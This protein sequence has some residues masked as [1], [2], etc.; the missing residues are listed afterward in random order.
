MLIANYKYKQIDGKDQIIFQN[1]RQNSFCLTKK[2]FNLN[3]LTQ[4]LMI[5]LSIKSSFA[6][7]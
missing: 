3:L 4:S 2:N 1:L 7:V 5:A 6:I